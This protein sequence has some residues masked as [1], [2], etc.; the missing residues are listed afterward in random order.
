MN[1][2]PNYRLAYAWI[3]VGVGLALFLVRSSRNVAQV[4]PAQCSLYDTK[5]CNEIPVKG[6]P[7]HRRKF[8]QLQLE[9]VLVKHKAWLKLVD[10]KE[11]NIP[12]EERADLSNVDLEGLDL[13]NKDLRWA[14]LTWASFGP[15]TTDLT[16]AN[17]GGAELACSD[18]RNAELTNTKFNLH[19]DLTSVVMCKANFYHADLEEATLTGSNLTDASLW[20]AKLRGAYFINT[21]LTN[22]A[23]RLDAN[24]LPD[25]G[26]W[27]SNETLF[28]ARLYQP[29]PALLRQMADQAKVKEQLRAAK[30]LTVLAK[31]NE[32][33]GPDHSDFDRD[34][35]WL[36]FDATCEYGMKPSRP[37]QILGLSLVCFALFYVY[38][39]QTRSSRNGIWIAWDKDR[40]LD[41]GEADQKMRL[42]DGFPRSSFS[43]TQMG[44]MVH[45]LGLNIVGLALWFSLMSATQI[46]YGA[47]NLGVWFSR[48]QP[49]EYTLRATG[50]VRVVSGL[51]SLVSVY[52]IALWLLTYFVRPFE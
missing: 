12:K 26:F 8:T 19:A 7:P 35:Y 21:N 2:P 25:A 47:L 15:K 18:L 24:S 14:D 32:L 43:G 6:L 22:A 48:M 36:L 1:R 23:L 30:E 16:N 28:Q 41:Q 3:L 27:G 29:D 39:Q 49:R 50:W 9:E 34:F 45:A 17:L 11:S 51:Q 10:A 20:G 40:I 31:R 52:L 5:Y 37:L 42:V 38:G 44:K 13:R 4:Y 33:Q 46:G